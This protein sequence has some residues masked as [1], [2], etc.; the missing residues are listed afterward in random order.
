[1]GGERAWYMRR[2]RGSAGVAN[3]WRMGGAQAAWLAHRLHEWCVGGAQAAW[4]AHRLHGWRVV[5]AQVAWVACEWHTG[6]MGGVWVAHRLHGWHVAACGMGADGEAAASTCASSSPI[7]H[8][9]ML[10]P[11]TSC[12]V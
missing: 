2:T 5:G 3:R 11:P 1:M 12:V 6:C 4:L 7:L 9:L 8:W 10:S